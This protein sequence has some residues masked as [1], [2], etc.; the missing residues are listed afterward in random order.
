MKNA[1]SYLAILLV[2]TVPFM[3]L[4]TVEFA[5]AQS[6]PKPS[7]PQFSVHWA[8]RSYDIP[9]TTSTDPYTGKSITNPA[10]HV[11]N[12]TITLR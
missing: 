11:T 8:D 7:V 12:K 10:Q 2:I 5:S 6:N 1:Y 9:Q 3:A 4:I